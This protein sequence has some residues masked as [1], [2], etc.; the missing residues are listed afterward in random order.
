VSAKGGDPSL[1]YQAKKN[2]PTRWLKQQSKFCLV[3]SVQAHLIDKAHSATRSLGSVS[4]DWLPIKI[5]LPEE[6]KDVLGQDDCQHGPLVL[7]SPTSA[8]FR[9]PMS[10]I[11]KAPFKV[12]FHCVPCIPHVSVPFDVHYIVTNDTS[13]HQLLSVVLDSQQQQEIKPKLLTC[14]FVSR[15]LRLAPRETKLV[16]YTAI[17]TRPGTMALPS[18]YIASIRYNAWVVNEGLTNQRQLCI[19]P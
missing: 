17:A 13:Y 10:S 1:L 18:A 15:D 19:L 9:G 12:T 5:D 8:K 4:V 2:E 11:E 3:S 7:A 6:A 14:G 16:S